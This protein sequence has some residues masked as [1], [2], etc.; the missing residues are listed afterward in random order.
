MSA[1]SSPGDVHGM[2]NEYYKPW[3][4]LKLL[5]IM[6]ELACASGKLSAK[7]TGSCPV[8]Q[9]AFDSDPTGALCSVHPCTSE[10][11][12]HSRP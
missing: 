5:G 4:I 2:D 8:T 3:A 1:G 11:V 6:V 10:D 12:V 7:P 9:D